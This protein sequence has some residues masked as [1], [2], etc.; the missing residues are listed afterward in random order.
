MFH[1]VMALYFKMMSRW[2]R[3]RVIDTFPAII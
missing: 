3:F 1:E 2:N